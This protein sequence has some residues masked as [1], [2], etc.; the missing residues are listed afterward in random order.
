MRLV[1]QIGFYCHD[2]HHDQKQLREDRVCF[3]LLL[4]GHTS[5]LRRVRTG[6]QGKS[7][8]AAYGLLIFFLIQ[9]RTTSPGIALYPYINH[10]LRKCPTTNLHVIGWRQGF[11]SEITLICVKLTK[12]LMRVVGSSIIP[13]ISLHQ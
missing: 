3:S 9:S 12:E 4:P 11:S 13:H 6:T 5:S 2:K 8:F 10:R 7:W 1:S